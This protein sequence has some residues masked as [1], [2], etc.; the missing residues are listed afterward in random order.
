MCGIVGGVG[1]IKEVK[2][3]IKK[4][5]KRIKHRGTHSYG[6]L[7]ITPDGKV[8]INR[9]LNDKRIEF[10]K[11]F[12]SLEKAYG[13]DKEIFFIAHNRYATI[14]AVTISN[15]HPIRYKNWIV[16]QNG[17]KEEFAKLFG[18]AQDTKGIALYLDSIGN[19]II[20][21][22]Q[23]ESFGKAFKKTGVVMGYNVKSKEFF[24]H[25]DGTRTLYYNPL[26]KLFASEPIDTGTWF[27]IQSIN[28][29]VKIRDS[30]EALKKLEQFIKIDDERFPIRIETI[31]ELYIDRCDSCGRRRVI[32]DEASSGVIERVVCANC[33][34]KGI[35]ADELVLE[36]VSYFRRI[37]LGKKKKSSTTSK[38]KV[39]STKSIEKKTVSTEK[40]SVTNQVTSRGVTLT[41]NAEINPV[42]TN[43][44]KYPNHYN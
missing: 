26:K 30:H 17:T 20:N 15:A 23:S 1:T 6:V 14:G 7:V 42:W 24:F 11:L 3:N 19:S 4:W 2:S 43:L 21:R 32:V 12:E 22:Y 25:K 38:K 44:T 13:N 39:K 36:R 5:Q 9:T 29:V 35:R 41:E 28:K 18:V 10:D 40:V 37:G 27:Y 34:S 31:D 16:I 33:F 8:A